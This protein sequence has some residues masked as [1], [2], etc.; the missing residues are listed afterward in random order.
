M[1]VGTRKAIVVTAIAALL[2]ASCGVDPPGE[3]GTL[4]STIT[5]ADAARKVDAYAEQGRAALGSDVKFI[6]PY[7]DYDFPCSNADGSPS[8]NRREASVGY[9][10]E[11]VTLEQIPVFFQK[12][13]GYWEKAGFLI[14]D[15]DKKGPFLGAK[16]N[17]DGF[18]MG[19]KANHLNEIYLNVSSPCVWRNGTPEPTS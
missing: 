19:L 9:Q 4:E 1:N 3:G 10:L 16:H 17:V 14:T 5:L 15:D 6:N 2:L 13:R 7:K 18:K 11:G 12:I 8:K